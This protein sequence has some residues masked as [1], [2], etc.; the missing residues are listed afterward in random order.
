MLTVSYNLLKEI[1]KH[2]TKYM[3]QFMLEFCSPLSI[4]TGKKQKKNKSLFVLQHCHLISLPLKSSDV[5]VNGFLYLSLHF[6]KYFFFVVW[7]S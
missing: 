4:D 1:K 2:T 7:L 5:S 3:F 6:I